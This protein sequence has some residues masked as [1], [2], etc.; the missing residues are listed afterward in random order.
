MSNR[1]RREIAPLPGDVEKVPWGPQDHALHL[2]TCVG[3]EEGPE[4][5]GGHALRTRGPPKSPSAGDCPHPRRSFKKEE[6]KRQ[7][8]VTPLIGILA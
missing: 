8:F 6:K 3:E 2:I 4:R 1:P 7:V 5:A